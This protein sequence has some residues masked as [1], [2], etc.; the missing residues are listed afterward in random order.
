[1]QELPWERMQI[2]IGGGGKTA[3]LR[4]TGRST[5]SMTQA[6]R[7]ARSQIS[8]NTRFKLAEVATEVQVMRVLWTAAWSCLLEKK[9]DAATAAMAKY[10]ASD[11]EGKVLDECLQ[12]H[13]GYGLHV[14][15]PDLAS[16]LWMRA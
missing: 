16:L 7:Q 15:V 2:A 14:G 9:L 12:L 4:C 5:S 6:S 13:G 3:R 10:W 8:R 11:M 1:M